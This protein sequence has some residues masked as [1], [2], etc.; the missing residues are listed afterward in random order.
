M[1][2]L[3]RSPISVDVTNQYR[4]VQEA[5]ASGADPVGQALEGAGNAGFEIASRMA[6]AKIAAD[7]A[8]AT[9]KLR[10]RL[11]E[12]SRAIENDMEGDPAGFEARFRQ[13]AAEIANEEAGRMSSPAMKR[14]FGMKSMELTETYSINMRDVTRRRQVEGVKAQTMKVGADYE[15]LAKDPAKPRELLDAARDDYLSLID[16]QVKAGIYTPD[17][18]EAARIAAQEVYQSG[19]TTRHLTNLDDLMDRERYGEAELYL[20]ANDHEMIPAEAQKAREVF[21][22][23][24]REGEAV[25]VADDLWNKSGGNYDL[26]LTMI[27][28]DPRVQGTD[29]LQAVEARGAVRKN[30]GVAAEEAADQRSLTAGMEFI[31]TGR[32]VPASV[33]R[34][35]SPKVRDMLQTEQRTRQLWAQQMATASAEE[36]AALRELSKGNYYRLKA[37]LASPESKSMTFDGLLADPA[38][39]ALYEN[40]TLDE[41]GQFYNDFVNNK[42]EVGADNVLK[43]YK[44]VIALAGAYLPDGMTGEGFRKKFKRVGEGDPADPRGN[45]GK[46]K[47]PA[48]IDLEGAILRLVG[49]EL[50]RTGGATIGPDRAEQLVALGYQESGFGKAPE[51]AMI[52]NAQADMQARILAARNEDPALW[53][54]ASSYIRSVNPNASEAVIYDTYMELQ[55]KR[56]ARQTPPVFTQ[57]ER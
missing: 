43:E 18:A 19:V 8:E 26:F 41:Q 16:Q 53:S 15:T 35:A 56:A 47:S 29:M 40:M 50:E 42:G 28:E 13:R 39:G 51:A 1:A 6:D 55:D 25:T 31:T 52:G 20:N 9:I 7:A 27:R 37:Q 3:P 12:E 11:D 22:T 38:V 57:G 45:S 10:S 49:E 54:K 30:Q 46:K 21:E 33:M 34:E 2:K 32:P 17:V 4:P 14:A 5:R 23:K 24:K 48:A 36:K 44:N